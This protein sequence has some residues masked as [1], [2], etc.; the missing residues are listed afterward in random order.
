MNIL[1]KII[2]ITLIANNLAFG[3]S[4]IKEKL[5][6]SYA[7]NEQDSTLLFRKSM[8][9][10]SMGRLMQKQNY[11]YH[12]REKGQ[13]IKEE[14]AFFNTSTQVLKEEIID[15]PEGKDPLRQKLITKY[16]DYQAKEKDSKYIL[17]QLFDKY[18]E[19]SKE[20]T[21]TYDD[22]QN[23]IELCSYVYTGSTSLSCNYYT[24]K[25]G[26]QTRWTTYAKWNTINAKGDVVDRSGK[27]RDYRYRYN[28][29]GKLTRA[30][31]KY[32]KN[33]FRQKITYDSQGRMKE[34]R[35]IVKR[36]IKQ[37]GTKE[38]PAKKK[39]RIKKEEHII[40]YEGGRIV[41]DVKLLNKKEINRK[42]FSYENGVV[43]SIQRSVNGNLL[44]EIIYRYN[45]SLKVLEKNSTRYTKNRKVHYRTSSYYDEN[46]NIIREE[47]NMAG[48]TLSVKN[49]VYDDKGNPIEQ[50]L[51]TQNNKSLE[52]TLYIY[53]YH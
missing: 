24:Y 51:S 49:Y 42:D 9:Y 45:K 17:R 38:A 31:G 11:Y 28:K 52:K 6:L 37:V 43:V 22:N 30:C 4:K 1:L 12:S 19:I 32:Y 41:S 8:Q 20:D 29:E 35:S 23:L 53:K 27:R 50:S 25:N 44:E 47:Q 10:D 16:L 33:K 34:N 15:Y 48:K 5:V 39:Y 26:L 3:Q 7:I 46:E 36:K 13:L 14:K 18:G 21:L 40:S 2:F